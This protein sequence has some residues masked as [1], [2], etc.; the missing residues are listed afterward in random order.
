RGSPV[1]SHPRA[2][3]LGRR[4]EQGRWGTRARMLSL[5]TEVAGAVLGG[6][7]FMIGGLVPDGASGRVEEYDV[8]ANTWRVRAPLPVALHHTAA[9]VAGGRLF[10]IG[11]FGLD[12]VAVNSMFE[13]DP[14]AVAW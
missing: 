9:A 11:G 13:Y 5:R 14:A 2:G 3:D 7:I 6:K 12:G 10:V 4:G 1:F 8:A